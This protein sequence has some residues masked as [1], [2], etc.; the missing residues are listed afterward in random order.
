M[1]SLSPQFDA[2]PMTVPSHTLDRVLAEENVGRVDLIKLDVEGFEAN[3]FRGAHRLLS[4][5][6]PP[7]IVFEFVDWAEARVATGRVGDA[8]RVLRE[9][10]F[11]LWRLEDY[12]KNG[13]PLPEILTEGSN[14]IV[15]ARNGA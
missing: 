14:M 2:T 6:R 7:L 9:Y 11:T 3:V 1:G 13:P 10:G 15:A 4:S 5:D 8:Q 12:A